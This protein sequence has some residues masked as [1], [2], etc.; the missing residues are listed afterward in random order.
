MK[1]KPKSGVL[2]LLYLLLSLFLPGCAPY[3]TYEE[4]E[5]EAQITGD[6]TKLEK[7]DAEAESAAD[8]FVNKQQCLETNGLVWMCKRGAVKDRRMRKDAGIDDLIRAHRREWAAG[9][10]CITSAG[11]RDIFRF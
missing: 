7:R 2:F 4:L 1:R 3:Q 11:M 6:N 10:G 8:F 9:C 5:A